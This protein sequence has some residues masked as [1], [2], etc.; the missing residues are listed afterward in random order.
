MHIIFLNFFKYGFV[1]TMIYNGYIDDP[2]N[3]DN[4]WVEGEIWNFHY[5]KEDFFDKRIKNA[6]SKWREVSSNVK[7]SNEIISDVLKEIAEMH[8]GFYN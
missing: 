1:P 3:T 7:N 2:K 6:P 5:D 8:D 4:A